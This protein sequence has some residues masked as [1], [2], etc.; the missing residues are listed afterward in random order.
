M[1]CLMSICQSV[2]LSSVCLS[3]CLSNFCLSVCLPAHRHGCD[4][5]MR[6]A[7]GASRILGSEEAIIKLGHCMEIKFFLGIF[8]GKMSYSRVCGYGVCSF[9]LNP[10]CAPN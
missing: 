9:S 7:M 8:V 2:Y 5:T 3:V 1:I 10:R 4:R 6:I